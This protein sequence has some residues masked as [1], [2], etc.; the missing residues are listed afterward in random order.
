MKSPV[1]SLYPLPLLILLGLPACGQQDAGAP[2]ESPATE[3]RRQENHAM[4]RLPGGDE[5]RSALDAALTGRVLAALSQDARFKDLDVQT[6]HGQVVLNGLVP[7]E[8]ARRRAGE[9][10]RSVDG[11]LGLEN[12]LQV[13]PGR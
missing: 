5:A 12:R 13:G 8:T 10:A 4:T 6:R 11:V 1:Q 2:E 3:L 7:D 9:L